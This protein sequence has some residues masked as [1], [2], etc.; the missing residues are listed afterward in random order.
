MPTGRVSVSV[1][2]DAVT[3]RRQRLPTHSSSA[4]HALSDSQKPG[5]ASHAPAAQR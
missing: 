4:P 5:M 2:E 3:R 1:V